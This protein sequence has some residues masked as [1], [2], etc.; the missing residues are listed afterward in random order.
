MLKLTYTERSFFLEYLTQPLEEWVA[1]RLILALRVGQC[2]CFEPS[3][4]AFLLPGDLPGIELLKTEVK[5]NDHLLSWSIGDADYLEVT[6]RGSWL[7]DGSVATVGVFVTTICEAT[8]LFLYKLWQ[9][10]QVSTPVM[11]D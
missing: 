2:L 5:L 7:S 10:S 8:E 1:Q 9:E 3:R 4:A 11:S 6:L